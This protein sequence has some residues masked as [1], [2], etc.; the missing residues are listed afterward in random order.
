MTIE[1]VSMDNVS[2]PPAID[3]FRLQF[4]QKGVDNLDK[5]SKV[6]QKADNK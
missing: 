6:F 5:K 4:V 1:Q 3:L 2:G